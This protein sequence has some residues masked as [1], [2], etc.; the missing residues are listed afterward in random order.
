MYLAVLTYQH[1]SYPEKPNGIPD[2]WP[3]RV[4]ELGDSPNLPDGLLASDGWMVM[5]DYDYI[6][7]REGLQPAYDAWE[8]QHNAPTPQ[9]LALAR[10]A[11][12]TAFGQKLVQQIE[13]D[14]I[15]AGLTPTQVAY[16]LRDYASVLAMLQSGSL[17]TA[18]AVAQNLQPV[19]G[20]TQERINEYVSQIRAFLGIP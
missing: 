17:V 2:G 16:M 1:L 7:Y 5:N 8:T 15:V 10:V 13:A 20:M 12:A 18:L 4:V 3:A 19:D 14:N 11:A 9:Q 6:S